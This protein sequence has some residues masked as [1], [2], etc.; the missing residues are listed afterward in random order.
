MEAV[1]RA[2]REKVEAAELAEKEKQAAIL[3]EQ[4]KAA[5]EALRVENE[6]KAKDAAE[7][8]RAAAE[9]AEAEKKAANVQHQK[10]VN[11]NAVAALVNI[12]ITAEIAKSVI[13]AIAKGNV[14]DVTINY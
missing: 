2:E 6:R 9:K 11:N 10:D 12:G 5:A 4:Q 3:A 8:A 1:A 7:A 14:P 13:T